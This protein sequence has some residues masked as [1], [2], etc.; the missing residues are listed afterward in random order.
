MNAFTETET[1]V[2]FAIANF[3]QLVTFW[4]LM[5]DVLC[6]NWVLILFTAPR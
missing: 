1:G 3:K 5:A 2:M 4:A 6:M